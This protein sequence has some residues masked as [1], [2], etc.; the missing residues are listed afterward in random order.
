LAGILVIAIYRYETAPETLLHAANRVFY[1]LQNDRS[2]ILYHY[3]TQKERDFDHLTPRKIDALFQQVYANYLWGAK[4]DGDKDVYE[5]DLLNGNELEY[6]K[7]FFDSQ[8]RIFKIIL[9][10]YQTESG[11]KV[12]LGQISLEVFL[13]PFT[14]IENQFKDL[15]TG[16]KA[17]IQ[18]MNQQADLQAPML[19]QIGLSKMLAIS[20]EVQSGFEV[21]D[22]TK[23]L[24]RS[25]SKAR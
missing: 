23:Y 20:P 8:G 17:R 16:I 12:S 24:H 6:D 25:D 7:Y 14:K 9:S 18:I 3:I 13:I 1:A 2:D 21:I 4:P 22:F 5:S 10:V 19:I 15:D 11:P